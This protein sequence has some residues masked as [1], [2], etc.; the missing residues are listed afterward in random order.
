MQSILSLQ[1][2]NSYPLPNSGLSL[3]ELPELNQYFPT[4]KKRDYMWTTISTVNA[5]ETSKLIQNER[6]GQ[7]SKVTI[8]QDQ[9]AEVNLALFNQIKVIISHNS[10]R[11][12]FKAYDFNV[13]L[14][15]RRRL[16]WM[17]KKIHKASS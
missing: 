8:E 13:N 14:L 6:K 15:S 10:N 1:S 3:K 11:I 7:M 5:E 4:L 9:L 17:K 16:L 12:S 2:I